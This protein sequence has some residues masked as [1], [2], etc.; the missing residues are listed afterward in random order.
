ML[1]KYNYRDAKCCKTCKHSRF[2]VSWEEVA[3]YCYLF[4]DTSIGEKTGR[5][6]EVYH[7]AVCDKYEPKD[8]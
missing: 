2:L 3:W 5:R 6:I 7:T 8:N 1:A 4:I